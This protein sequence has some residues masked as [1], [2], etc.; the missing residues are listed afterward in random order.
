MVFVRLIWKALS[1]VTDQSHNLLCVFLV[2][3]ENVGDNK[4]E[5][6]VN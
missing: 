2:V 3:A 6:K 1:G 5:E 4:S